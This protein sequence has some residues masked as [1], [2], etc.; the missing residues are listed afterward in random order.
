[1]EN[2]SYKKK[3]VMI[4]EGAVGKTSLIRKFVK[5]EFDEKYISTIGTVTSNKKVEVGN[6]TVDFDIWDV[7]GQTIHHPSLSLRHY[8]GAHGAIAVFD[9]TRLETLM[10]QRIDPKSQQKELFGLYRYITDLHVVAGKIPLVLVGNKY[11]LIQNFKEYIGIDPSAAKDPRNKDAKKRFRIFMEDMN[12]NVIDYYK[13]NYPSDFI[14]ISFYPVTEE[15]LAKQE[16]LLREKLNLVAPI[17]YFISSAKTG[18]NVE[19]TFKTLAELILE[20][21]EK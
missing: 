6:T 15:D 20:R 13:T 12:A 1:M 8:S 11:D 4:G 18:E 14:D 5:N 16:K 21:L 19:K 17:P 9:T 10:S 2:K 3:I 7:A